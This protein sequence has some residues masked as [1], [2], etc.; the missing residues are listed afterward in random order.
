MQLG[1]APGQAP[2]NLTAT[3]DRADVTARADGAFEVA[4]TPTVE[5]QVFWFFTLRRRDY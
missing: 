3:Y 2:A 5:N 4:L 1:N